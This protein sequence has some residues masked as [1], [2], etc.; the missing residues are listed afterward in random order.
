[1]GRFG[2]A[3]RLATWSGVAP[4][5]EES[6]GKHRSGMTR[7]GNQALR[8]GLTPWALSTYCLLPC[9]S[10]RMVEDS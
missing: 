7:P 1:M 8:T 4:G 3:A 2:T 10:G 5:H 9:S 6:A